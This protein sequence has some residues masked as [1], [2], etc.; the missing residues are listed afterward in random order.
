MAV[1]R[2][3]SREKLCGLEQ[4]REMQL[5][6]AKACTGVLWAVWALTSDRKDQWPDLACPALPTVLP[7]GS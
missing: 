6:E 3:W 7:V 2:Q 1:A 5:P 4:E